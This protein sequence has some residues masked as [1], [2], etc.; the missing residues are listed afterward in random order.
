MSRT[1]VIGRPVSQDAMAGRLRL[2]AKPGKESEVAAF[3]EGALP[4]AQAE[5][6]TATW[7]A[8]RI[9]ATTFGIFDTFDDEAGRGAHLSGPIAQALMGRADELLARAPV[10]EKLQLLAA[11]LSAR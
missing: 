9:D 3:L 10:I 4:L 11:K 7:Y 1:A 6:G 8:F 2:E 5:Q